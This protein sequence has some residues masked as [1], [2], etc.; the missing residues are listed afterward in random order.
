MIKKIVAFFIINSFL[1][2]FVNADLSPLSDDEMS[3]HTGQALL[4]ID[5]TAPLAGQADISFTRLTLG[6][7]IE[8]NQTI[9]ELVIGRYHRDPGTSCHE[10]GRFCDNTGQPFKKW[11]CSASECGG[12]TK[13]IFPD[14][15]ERNP[16]SASAV[17]YGDILNLSVGDQLG[18]VFGALLPGQGEGAYNGGKPFTD[19]SIFPSG[20]EHTTDTD[21]RLRDV[22]LGRVVHVDEN[23]QRDIN[24]SFRKLEPFVIERPFVEFA[25]DNSNPDV[26]KIAGL[27]IGFGSATGSQGNAIDVLTGFVKPVV[28]A[29]AKVLGGLGELLGLVGEFNFAPYLGGVRTPGYIDAEK[30]HAGLCEGSGII[31]DKVGTGTDIAH[32][33]PQ[34]QLFPLQNVALND[35]PSFWFSFQSQAVQYA[36]DKVNKDTGEYE[37]VYEEAQPGAW[38][39]LGALGLNRKDSNG[40]YQPLDFNA[41]KTVDGNEVPLHDLN[42]LSQIS[43]FTANTQQPKHPDNYFGANAANNSKYPQ[44]NNYY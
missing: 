39:N 31:C 6:L 27:R 20:F 34:A 17:V 3:T 5:E 41:K 28:T 2:T 29:R 22:S 12:F 15:Q 38:I 18:A 30:S 1:C 43:G 24:G 44:S 37:I 26:R 11:N 25:Y 4:K 9:D 16:F 42:L 23:G 14:G 7:K 21:I 35:S 10:R 33:S 40:V 8:V 19:A 32:A 36:S 13:D